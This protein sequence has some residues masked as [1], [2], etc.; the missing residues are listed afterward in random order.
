MGL[1]VRFRVSL[2]CGE[3]RAYSIIEGVFFTLFDRS[4]C[5]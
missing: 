5:T 2:K 1:R 3:V 4:A